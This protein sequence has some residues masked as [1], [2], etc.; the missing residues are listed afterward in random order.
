MDSYRKE[1]NNL[2]VDLMQQAKD[3]LGINKKSPPAMAEI[4]KALDEHLD[5]LCKCEARTHGF[6]VTGPSGRTYSIQAEE[7]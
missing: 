3:L 7:P 5:G 6:K 4:G 1:V 2:M